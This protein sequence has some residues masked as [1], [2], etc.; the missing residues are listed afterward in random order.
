MYFPTRLPFS[1]FMI[2]LESVTWN[3]HYRDSKWNRASLIRADAGATCQSTFSRPFECRR[4]VKRFIRESLGIIDA[5]SG[6]CI[7]GSR[8]STPFSKFVRSEKRSTRRSSRFSTTLN[9]RDREQQT[10][11]AVDREFYRRFKTE[12]T[13]FVNSVDSAWTTFRYFENCFNL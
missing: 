10:L 2:T 11:G 5:L 3:Q 4:R 8:A 7:D 13:E 9:T 6:R 1:F 12:D